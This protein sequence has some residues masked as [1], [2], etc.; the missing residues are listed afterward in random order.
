MFA[1]ALALITAAS[2]FVFASASPSPG[3]SSTQQCD[4]GE[5]YCCNS[6]HEMK[7]ADEKILAGLQLAGIDV[8]DLTGMI[9]AQ[10]SPLHV[11]A[12][13]GNHCTSQQVCCQKNFNNG[14]IVASCS[15]ID[16]SV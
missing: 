1:R 4:A 10:C 7:T 9:G 14:I 11:L 8:S 2:F 5:V 13:G 16:L 15:P 3:G 12:A 6:T